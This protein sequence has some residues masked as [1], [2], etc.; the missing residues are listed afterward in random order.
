ML[1]FLSSEWTQARGEALRDALGEPDAPAM[2]ADAAGLA[3]RS[4][5]LDSDAAAFDLLR[6]ALGGIVDAAEP[7]GV[8]R[9]VIRLP[10]RFHHERGRLAFWL[11]RRADQRAWFVPHAGD[12]RAIA[13][14]IRA[15]VASVRLAIVEPRGPTP[16]RIETPRL[17]LTFA[18]PSQSE[19]YFGRIAGT[20]VF[21]NLLWD[22][23]RS[24]A[25]LIEFT[26]LSA[27]NHARG[28]GHDY[29][30]SIIER[31][32]GDQVGGCSWRPSRDDRGTGTIGYMI[33]TPWQGRGYG[34]EAVGALVDEVFRTRGGERI[35]ADV[36]V[37]NE[38]SARL[39]EKLGFV[40]EGER[41]SRAAKGGVRR[42]E[43]TYALTKEEWRARSGRQASGD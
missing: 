23:P 13:G 37:G 38:A 39:L 22:G 20:R 36:F 5:A 3:E 10:E 19:R 28:L 42:D 7:M 6:E 32:S 17:V 1:V 18:T 9:H 24:P 14:E 29:R 4:P 25:D 15:G 30:V 35:E 8:R 43:W 11:L 2:F 12:P 31:S 21:E 27:R 41:R 34:T 26:M 16:P 33:A 40:R